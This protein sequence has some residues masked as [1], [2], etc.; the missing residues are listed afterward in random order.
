MHWVESL[1]RRVNRVIL[2]ADTDPWGTLTF[3]GKQE[4]LT[5]ATEKAQPGREKR[6][7]G[8][9]CGLRQA[10]RGTWSRGEGW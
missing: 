9:E 8:S 10:C 1:L 2:I 6:R 7:Q 5:K 4:D 3:G